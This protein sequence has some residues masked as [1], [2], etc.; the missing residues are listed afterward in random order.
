MTGKELGAVDLEAGA[1]RGF[2]RGDIHL[3]PDGSRVLLSDGGGLA[4]YHLPAGIQQFLIPGEF[5][6]SSRGIFTPDGKNVVQVLSCFDPKRP[7]ARV[8]VWDA[9]A[10][11][12]LTQVEVSDLGEVAAALSHDGK[13]IVTAGV[14][15]QPK[16]PEEIVVAGWES[17]SGKK[18]GEYTVQKRGFGGVQVVCG[19]DNRSAVVITP[20]GEVIV[21]DVVAGRKLRDLTA[22][23]Q[24][25][26]PE[27][28]ISPDGNLVAVALRPELGT[29]QRYSVLVYDIATGKVRQT[30]QGASGNCSLLAFAPDGKLLFTGSADTTAL[31]W[32]LR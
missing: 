22:G 28:A 27:L 7:T 1:P 23:P 29:P 30:L 4:I 21:L 6:R 8:R 3:S 10:G 32:A 17:G 19:G 11:K 25:V 13:L 31:V 15:R 14:R 18:L 20:A 12:P 16:G 24:R 5:D 9:D 2:S 26:T